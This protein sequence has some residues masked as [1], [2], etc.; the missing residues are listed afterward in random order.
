MGL[1]LK[2]E[3]VNGVVLDLGREATDRIK[4]APAEDLVPA[5]I[6]LEIDPLGAFDAGLPDGLA[7][8]HPG[9][10]HLVALGDDAGPLVA[11][12]AHG[13]VVEEGIAN[14]LRGN[15]KTVGVQ[16]TDQS[17]CCHARPQLR[18][19]AGNSRRGR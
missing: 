19:A 3:L 18:S 11:Q 1:N 6:P 12:D 14:P 13:F 8:F 7:G 9:G 17:S 5:K 15:V 2:K 10:F 16:V 4:H